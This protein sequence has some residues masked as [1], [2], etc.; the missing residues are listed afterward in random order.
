MQDAFAAKGFVVVRSLSSEAGVVALRAV[1]DALLAAGGD[2]D[3]LTHFAVR[4]PRPL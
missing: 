4:A 3:Y 1:A 2:C